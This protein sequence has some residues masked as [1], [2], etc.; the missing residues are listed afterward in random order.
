MGQRLA[1]LLIT[2][3]NGFV[4]QNLAY[5]LCRNFDVS[6]VDVSSPTAMIKLS[7][8]IYPQLTVDFFKSLEAERQMPNIYEV[9]TTFDVIIHLAGHSRLYDGVAFPNSVF[10]NDTDSLLDVMDYCSKNPATKV[11]YVSDLVVKYPE[12]HKNP[13]SASKFIGETIVTSFAARF[14]LDISIVRLGTVFGAGDGD[15]GLL[16]SSFIKRCMKAVWESVEPGAELHVI[17]SGKNAEDYVSAAD[18]ADGIAIVVDDLINGGHFPIYELGTGHS[19]STEEIIHEF[20]GDLDIT[21]IDH[22]SVIDAPAV[23]QADINLWPSAWY[24]KN[25]ILDYIREWKNDGCPLD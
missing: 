16:N 25:T 20:V 24:P 5:R 14:N 18:A 6:I 22:D 1:K 13:Y 15:F 17:G 7:A 3:G 19:H 12:S 4:G 10:R 23:V 8:K 21:V 11:I 9:P 2:G